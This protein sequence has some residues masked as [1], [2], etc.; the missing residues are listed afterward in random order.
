MQGAHTVVATKAQRGRDR[1]LAGM[2]WREGRGMALSTQTGGPP[3][4]NPGCSANAL[5]AVVGAEDWGAK[6]A[7]RGGPELLERGREGRRVCRHHGR[8]STDGSSD[9]ALRQK[10]QS[11]TITT[12]MPHTP[13]QVMLYPTVKGGKL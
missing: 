5:W 13:H 6:R 7:S 11:K 10:L 9:S 3:R 2:I 4:A 12:F 8:S 1:R